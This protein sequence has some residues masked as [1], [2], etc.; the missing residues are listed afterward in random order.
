MAQPKFSI[1][2]AKIDREVIT[3]GIFTSVFDLARKLRRLHQRILCQ[4]LGQSGGN[5]LTHPP[6]PQ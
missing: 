3:R 4:W 6:R 2:F 5:T 1:W